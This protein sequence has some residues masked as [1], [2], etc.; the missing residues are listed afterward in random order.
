M[1]QITAAKETED[2][3]CYPESKK[4]VNIKN[5]VKTFFLFNRRL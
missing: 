5:E 4:Y 1:D 3:Y 2:I